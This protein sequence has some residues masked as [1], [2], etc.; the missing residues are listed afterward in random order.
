MKK[1]T[2]EITEELTPMHRNLFNDMLYMSLKALVIFWNAR[3]KKS[4]KILVNGN[5]IKHLDW[6]N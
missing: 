2:I 6:I 3:S 5:N 1:I 4:F